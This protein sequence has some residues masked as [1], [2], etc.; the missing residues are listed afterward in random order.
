MH[1]FSA[2]ARMSTISQTFT[3]RRAKLYLY[4]HECVL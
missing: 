1:L 3:N 2:A 4:L